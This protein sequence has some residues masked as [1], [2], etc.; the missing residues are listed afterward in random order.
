M[1]LI[2]TA[3]SKVTIEERDELLKENESIKKELDYIKNTTINQMYIND[4]KDLRKE[5]ERD[6]K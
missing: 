1:E 2:K 6:F 4:L 3:M 5:I